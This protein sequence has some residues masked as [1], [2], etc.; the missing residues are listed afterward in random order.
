MGWEIHSFIVCISA[1]SVLF[2]VG[3]VFNLLVLQ[4]VVLSYC[5]VV[6]VCCDGSVCEVDKIAGSDNSNVLSCCFLH[7]HLILPCL[8]G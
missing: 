5:V 6:V 3:M 4:S 7:F 2:L 8:G 1:L